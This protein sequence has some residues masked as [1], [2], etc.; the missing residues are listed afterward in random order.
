MVSSLIDS[1]SGVQS[2]ENKVCVPGL[3]T[4]VMFTERDDSLKRDPE[5]YELIV[6]SNDIR[7]LALHFFT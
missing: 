2:A 4:N 6:K 3:K 5:T 7:E 1:S